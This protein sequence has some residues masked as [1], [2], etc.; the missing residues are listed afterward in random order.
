MRV[1]HLNNVN[2]A[3]RA[4]ASAGVRLVNISSGDIVDGN[5]KLILG[6]VAMRNKCFEQK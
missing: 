4:L 2:A 5:P 3:L 1:H 6:N